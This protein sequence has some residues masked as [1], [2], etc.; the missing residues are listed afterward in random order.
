MSL[1]LLSGITAFPV[2]TEINLLCYYQHYF[3]HFLQGWITQLF[4]ELNETPEVMFYGTDWLAFAHMVISL[5]FIPV[6]LKPQHLPHQQH[7]RS[8]GWTVCH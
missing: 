1:L 8:A 2:K 5:F 7:H 6:Y 3:P 4:F